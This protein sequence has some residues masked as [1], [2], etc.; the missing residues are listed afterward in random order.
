MN[1]KTAVMAIVGLFA[2]VFLYT[3]FQFFFAG[4]NPVQMISTF[5]LALLLIGFII[6]L[7][8]RKA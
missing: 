6:A 3:G 8:F 1:G 4:I 2:I 7:A 5:A